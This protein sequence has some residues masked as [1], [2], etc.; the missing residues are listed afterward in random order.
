MN[1][2]KTW[3]WVILKR[4]FINSFMMKIRVITQR[5][6]NIYYAGTGIMHQIK[7]CVAR[8]FYVWSFS[9]NEEVPIYILKNIYIYLNTYTTVLLGNMAI[10]QKNR[11]NIHSYEN[12]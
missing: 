11:N 3:Y 6:Y 10:Q 9:N 5:L 8:M 2:F 7:Y 1:S 12:K 4:V